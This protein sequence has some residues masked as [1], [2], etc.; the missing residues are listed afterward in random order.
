MPPRQNKEKFQ[1]LTEFEREK[2]ISLREGGF[3]FRATGARV[4][5]NNSTMM[6]VWKQ[7]INERRT[8]RKTSSGRRKVTSIRDDQHLLHRVVND[9]TAS[10][11][12]LAARW[13]TGTGVL[14]S[15]S[16]IRRC[17]LHHGLRAMVPLYRTPLMANHRWLRLQWA[18]EHRD[19]QAN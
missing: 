14:M 12:Q 9:C 10:S 15:V 3:S 18:H 5:R 13:S 7:W 6:R 8:T 2:V 4:Q 17:L 11:R 19:W 16:S 1:Q